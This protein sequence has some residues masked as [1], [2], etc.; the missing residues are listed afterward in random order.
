MGR[1]DRQKAEKALLNVPRCSRVSRVGWA[2]PGGSL[3]VSAGP[4]CLRGLPGLTQR[5]AGLGAVTASS[6]SSQA[7]HPRNSEALHHQLWP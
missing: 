3:S 5:R 7:L 6:E 1:N 2:D 4:L